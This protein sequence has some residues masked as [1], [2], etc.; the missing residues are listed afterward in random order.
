MAKV[1]IV[2]DSPTIAAMFQRFLR[3]QGHEVFLAADGQTALAIAGR[4]SPDLIVLDQVLPDTDG[5]KIC[6]SLKKESPLLPGKVLILTGSKDARLEEL[7][8]EAGAGAYLTKDCGI[9]RI[10]EVAG[11]FLQSEV[12]R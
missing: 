9:A 8:R 2:D 12:G 11:K 7:G 3:A 1:L 10:F 4:E 6:H 5:F